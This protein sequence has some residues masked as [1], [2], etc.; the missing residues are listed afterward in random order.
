M[1]LV[2]LH[3]TPPSGVARL[4][5]FVVRHRD[6]IVSYDEAVLR[7]QTG[8]NRDEPGVL[9]FSF[10]DGFR[11]NLEA[12]R[13]LADQGVAACFFVPTDVV[14][15][16]RPDVDRFF[17]RPQAEGVVTWDDL[18]WLRNHGHAIG[19]HC[20]QHKDLSAMTDAAAEDQVKG[21]IEVLRTMVGEARHFAW[22]FGKLINAP[23]RKV[24]EWC[25]EAGA[26]AASGVRGRNT[27]SRLHHD[28]YLRRD[29]LELRWLET[30]LRVF[31]GR[32]VVAG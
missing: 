27:T 21:S 18:A 5:R 6:Q 4:E 3:N 25:A 20:R 11:S 10:D 24:T 22:P 13:M 14:G 32:D 1:T 15:L 26:S 16:K 7:C 8:E 29:A 19:S 28:G 12:G 31:R 23:V 17:G 9:A 30:D 2:L